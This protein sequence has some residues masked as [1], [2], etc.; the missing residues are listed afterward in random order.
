MDRNS[1]KFLRVGDGTHIL[2]ANTSMED[3]GYYRCIAT[4]IHKGKEYNIT[5]NIKLRVEGKYLTTEISVI[6]RTAG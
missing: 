3:A 2:I 5:R 6:P 4:F 1:K